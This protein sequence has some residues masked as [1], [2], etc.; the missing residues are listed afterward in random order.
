MLFSKRQGKQTPTVYITYT[1]TLSQHCL[2]CVYQAVVGCRQIPAPEEWP[3]QRARSS[4]AAVEHFIQPVP[5]LD[6]SQELFR[7]TPE[8]SANNTN[9]SEGQMPSWEK[10]QMQQRDKNRVCT[11]GYLQVSAASEFIRT[12]SPAS[13]KCKISSEQQ[14]LNLTE[15]HSRGW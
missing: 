14:R 10:G 11:G 9:C 5:A 4:Q 15:T 13:C 3:Y 8:W 6:L 2:P 12:K 7:K 1:L